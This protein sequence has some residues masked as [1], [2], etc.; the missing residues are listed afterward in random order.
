M[1]PDLMVLRLAHRLINGARV[2]GTISGSLHFVLFNK[3][4]AHDR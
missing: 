3:E 2:S 1:R 4:K